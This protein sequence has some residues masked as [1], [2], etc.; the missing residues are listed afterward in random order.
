MYEFEI[1]HSSGA[2]LEDNLVKAQVDD[3]EIFQIL[4][5]NG[6]NRF[7]IV[8]RREVPKDKE[9]EVYKYACRLDGSLREW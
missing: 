8:V 9:D 5:D 6:D 1:R 3:W 7:I 4:E 2:R